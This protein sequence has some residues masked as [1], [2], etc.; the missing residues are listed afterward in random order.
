MKNRHETTKPVAKTEGLVTQE[1]A[2]ELLV[3]DERKHKAHCLNET[4]WKIWEECTGEQNVAEISQRT[5]KKLKASVD[6]TMVWVALDE[7]SKNGLLQ[8]RVTVDALSR[9]AMMRRLGIGA[10]IAIPV[11]TSIIAPKAI[12]AAT[13]RPTGQS[14]TTGAQCCSGICSGT[15]CL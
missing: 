4:A 13:C 10:A 3:Y 6:E 9:R 1:L 7:L 15:T 14:C 2:D 11:V 5:S 12:T 8:E